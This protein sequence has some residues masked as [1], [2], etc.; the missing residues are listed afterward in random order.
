MTTATGQDPQTGFDQKS[1]DGDHRLKG[2]KAPLCPGNLNLK[3]GAQV[4]FRSAMGMTCVHINLSSRE[5]PRDTHDCISGGSVGVIRLS[6][7]VA[8]S[9]S[10]LDRLREERKVSPNKDLAVP[11]QCLR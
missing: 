9:V 10:M 1:V 2:R 7:P 3:I 4:E 11:M 5:V 8:I 6:I